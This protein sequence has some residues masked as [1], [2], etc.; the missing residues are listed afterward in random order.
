MELMLVVELLGFYFQ[1]TKKPIDSFIHVSQNDD[2]RHS[3]EHRMHYVP[4]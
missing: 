3:L 1:S 4:V 2:D